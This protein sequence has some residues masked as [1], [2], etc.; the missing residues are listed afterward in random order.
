MLDIYRAK[1]TQ[2]DYY[3][4]NDYAHGINSVESF[5][6]TDPARV[7]ELFQN[8]AVEAFDLERFRRVDLGKLNELCNELWDGPGSAAKISDYIW[9]IR[10]ARREGRVGRDALRGY[11]TPTMDS[12]LTVSEE[13][14]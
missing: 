4:G 8:L 2:H 12:E 7:P 1:A 9:D 13:D 10:I 5:N 3:A 14:Q 6:F 11:A